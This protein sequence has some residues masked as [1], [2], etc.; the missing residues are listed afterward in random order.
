[1]KALKTLIKLNKNK[2]DNI[3]RRLDYVE[4]EKTRLEEKKLE[5]EA[6]AEREIK[7]Y[8][9]TPYAYMLDRYMQNSRKTMQR[10]DAQIQQYILEIEG[11]R[12]DLRDQYAELKKFEIAL[13][14]KKKIELK[15]QRKMEAK[16]LDEFNI[17][18]FIYNKSSK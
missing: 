15:K 18:K 16:D 13:E 10:I 7:K 8:S 4:S 2:L 9:A 3:L 11:L 14:N 12:Q 6:D 17:N 5:I 1:M